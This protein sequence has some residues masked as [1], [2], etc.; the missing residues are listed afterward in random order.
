M[1]NPA[2]GTAVPVAYKGF[3]TY[4]IASP[5]GTTLA[6]WSWNNGYGSVA[7]VSWTT[8]SPLVLHVGPATSNCT[9]PVVFMAR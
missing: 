5:A 1:S 9:F 4:Q 2:V 6:T 8:G 3:V 7:D